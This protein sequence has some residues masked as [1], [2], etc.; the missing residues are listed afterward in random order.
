MYEY[1]EVN[2]DNAVPPL[3]AATL[4]E[5]RANAA[6]SFIQNCEN[7]LSIAVISYNRL[8]KTK[9]CVENLIKNTDLPYHLILIDSGSE[10][11]VLEYYK[12]IDFNNKTII[13]IT[14]N[15]NANFSFLVAMQSMTSKYCAIV[16]NDV[17]ITKNS[18][19]NLLTCMKS[20]NNIGWVSP[21]SSN[22]SNFQQVNLPFDTLEQ[23]NETAA[24]YNIS[25]PLKWHE[26]LALMPAI[27]FYKKE[28][29]DIVGGFDYGF[30]HDFA[31]DD[32]ARRINR[33]GYKTMLCKDAW[34]HH[35]HIYNTTAEEATKH[36]KSLECGRKNFKQKYYG[37]DAWDDIRNFEMELISSI[38]EP[39]HKDNI[40]SILGVDTRCG[41][42][43]LE[44][45]N[46]LRDYGVTK[47]IC[48]AFTSNPKYFFDLQT[49]CHDVACDRIDFLCDYYQPNSYDYILVG[50]PI[51]SY[52]NP[53]L[54]LKHLWDYLKPH[55]TLLVKL[56][57]TSNYK[58]LSFSL[59]NFN[60]TELAESS[61]CISAENMNS[62]F[63]NLGATVNQIILKQEHTASD[64]IENLKKLLKGMDIAN[65]NDMILAR[66]IT[67]D[68]LFSIEKS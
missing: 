32:M 30:F 66:L 64:T 29:I 24:K 39:K 3:E 13:R 16:S 60:N 51:N 49:I 25:N 19:Q 9:V 61:F 17:I 34:V 28:C 26:R 14:K 54:I 2:T 31:D 63:L 22:I 45:R 53:Y 35:N 44:I 7:E 1:L 33:A 59:G 41:T 5:S 4:I 23:M 56:Q 46:K 38:K 47:T 67:K 50:E 48:D 43:I 27:F 57:N 55:G 20:A 52:P 15:I 42:P 62:W 10:P 68:Y 12:S 58:N 37:L 21:V 36:S 8:D 18:I 6:Q 65:T 40:P 11:D